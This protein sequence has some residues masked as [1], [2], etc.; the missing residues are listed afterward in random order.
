MDIIQPDLDEYSQQ[1]TTMVERLFEDLREE[2]YAMTSEPHMQVGKVEGSFLRMLVQMIQ[3]RTVL[4]LGT[5]NGYSALM[6][7]S[8]LPKGGVLYTLDKDEVTGAI[9]RRYFARAPFGHKIRPVMGDARE[10]I[11]TIKGPVDLAF[12]DADKSSYDLYYE[13]ALRLLRPQGMMALDNMLW[14]GKVLDPQDED[15]RAIHLLNQKIA[16]DHRVEAVLLTIRDG[17]MLVRKK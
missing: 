10:T 14:S 4:E 17:V 2:T 5:F 12:I 1:Y 15:S 7:A 16:R 11:R 3:A 8:G 6:M 13:E 9:A